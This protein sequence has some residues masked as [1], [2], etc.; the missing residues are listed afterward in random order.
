MKPLHKKLKLK[1]GEKILVLN[2][3]LGFDAAMN[4]LPEGCSV[5]ATQLRNA[6]VV[7]C[8]VANKK[9]LKSMESKMLSNLNEQNKLWVAYPKGSSGMQTDLTRDNGWENL[10]NR[11]NLSFVAFISFDDVWSIFC[12]RIKTEADKRKEAK[13][14][15][16]EIVKYADS[17]TKTITLPDDMKWALKENIKA[18]ALFDNLAFSHRREYVEWVV[19]AKREETRTKRING[20][21]EMLLRGQKNPAGR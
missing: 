15:V 4:P 6:D 18:S 16:R 7:F 5:H 11:S 10:M 17:A 20:T 8:F 3:P 1:E 14:R 13:P 19:T 9:E 2:K 21:I 12:I